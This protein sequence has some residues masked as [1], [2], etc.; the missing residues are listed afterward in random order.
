MSTRLPA[1]G[2]RLVP[3]KSAF[4]GRWTGRWPGLPWQRSMELE[5]LGP[6]LD[7]FGSLRKRRS[8]STGW[9][10]SEEG[11]V[12]HSHSRGARFGARAGREPTLCLHRLLGLSRAQLVAQLLPLPVS[13]AHTLSLLRLAVELMMNGLIVRAFCNQLRK[14][15]DHRAI[16]K[17]RMAIVGRLSCVLPYTLLRAWTVDV[18]SL[19]SV[20]CKFSFLSG[21]KSLSGKAFLFRLCLVGFGLVFCR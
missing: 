20:P 9:E 7:S 14:A 4:V 16:W 8:R 21:F 11:C 15:Y 6:A 2:F 3:G 12:C 10:G 17:M 18:L 5:A 13:C 1:A 19:F